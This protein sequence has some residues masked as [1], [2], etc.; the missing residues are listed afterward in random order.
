MGS[1]KDLVHTIPCIRTIAIASCTHAGKEKIAASTEV[2]GVHVDDLLHDGLKDMMEFGSTI[3]TKFPPNSFH[4]L[5][6]EEQV[7]ACQKSQS[8]GDGIPC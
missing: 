5:F 8:R 1:E 2:K 3:E 6:W 7:K 4:R